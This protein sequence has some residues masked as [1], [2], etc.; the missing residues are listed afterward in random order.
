M[1]S[2]KLEYCTPLDDQICF[3]NVPNQSSSLFGV[4]SS[5]LKIVS[6][7]TTKAGKMNIKYDL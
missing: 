4:Y 1:K 3:H 5:S 2:D 6:R 7:L